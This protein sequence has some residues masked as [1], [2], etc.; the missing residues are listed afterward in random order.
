MLIPGNWIKVQSNLCTTITLGAQKYWLLFL[1][2]RYSEVNCEK[3]LYTLTGWELGGSLLTGGRQGRW[4]WLLTQVWLYCLFNFFCNYSKILFAIFSQLA[5]QNR[6]SNSYSGKR[7]S[8]QISNNCQYSHPWHSE[9]I[10][11]SQLWQ[12]NSILWHCCSG[13]WKCYFF[14]IYQSSLSSRVSS[15]SLL[16]LIFT[17]KMQNFIK[18]KINCHAKIIFCF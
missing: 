11:S 14:Q 9:S 6:R 8:N 3:L 7:K 10:S 16:L 18:M 5:S 2:G 17:F 12:F 4:R 13:N 1:S 15:K